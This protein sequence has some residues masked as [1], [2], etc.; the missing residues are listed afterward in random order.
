MKTPK[1][2]RPSLF[3]GQLA[4]SFQIDHVS[5]DEILWQLMNYKYCFIGSAENTEVLLSNI[6][7]RFI[8]DQD[9]SNAGSA[10]GAMA[11]SI[12][13]LH[14]ISTGSPTVHCPSASSQ[15]Q[16]VRFSC[17]RSMAR[18]AAESIWN[19]FSTYY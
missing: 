7:L 3:S 13:S 10:H 14:G 8:C 4:V 9:A 17:N 2:V 11:V 1:A 18:T 15:A 5:E 6:L 12:S 16:G 19:P